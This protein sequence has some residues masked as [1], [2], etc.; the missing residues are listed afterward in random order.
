MNWLEAAILGFIQGVTE[1]LPISSTGHLYIGRKLFGLQDAGLFLDTMLHIGTFIALIVFYKDI[2]WKLI[3]Q[4]FSKLVLLLAAGTLPAVAAGLL[5]KDFFDGISKTG[6]TI[7]WEFIFTALFLFFADRTKAGSRKLD[8]LNIGDAVWIG[9][10]QALAIFPAVSRSGL[11][12]AG[13]LMRGIDKET[14][15]YFSFLLSIPAVFGALVFQLKDLAE[16]TG[17]AIGL[18]SMLIA[19]ISSSIFG[20][21]AVAF[22]INFVKKH[23]LKG[24]AL[25][26]AVLGAGILLLQSL[27]I[28]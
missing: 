13:A 24:F 23:S 27:K 7:G 19:T 3:K 17:P 10:F 8:Q 2:L 9:S 5:F 28:F 16:Y 1:F 4:P 22:M 20:Y 26:V 11:T 12:I 25:Y 18:P 6:M 21:I 14:A 15:A